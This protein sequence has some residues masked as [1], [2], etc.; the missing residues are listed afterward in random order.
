MNPFVFAVVYIVLGAILGQIVM[1][2]RATVKLK[3]E[4]AKKALQAELDFAHERID[5]ARKDMRSE[6]D[7]IHQ[8]LHR[9]LAEVEHLFIHKHPASNAN[10][11]GPATGGQATA[12]SVA[13]ASAGKK[14]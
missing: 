13:K 4:A 2:Y 5:S 12:Q 14:A 1:K 6:M 11:A 9:R 3:V 10:T 8:S 7:D